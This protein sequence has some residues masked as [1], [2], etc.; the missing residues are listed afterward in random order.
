MKVAII[1][2]NTQEYKDKVE[3]TAGAVIQRMVEQISF[4][5]VF[6]QTLPQDRAI[7]TTVMNRLIDGHLVD[8]IIT[9]GGTG[10]REE[11]CV[12]EATLDAVDRLLPGIPEAVRAYNIRYSKRNLLD[13]SVAGMRKKT[14]IVNLPDTAK[15]AKESL[16]YILPELVHVVETMSLTN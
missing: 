4:Q 14:L 9:T 1:T 7:L 15:V 13:R 16:E 10:A 5:T 8:L 6:N 11:D 3:S 12:P 2:A